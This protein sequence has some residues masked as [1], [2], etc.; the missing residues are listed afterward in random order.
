MTDQNKTREGLILE[1]Q[2]LQQKQ[3]LLES[4]YNKNITQ[5]KQEQAKLKKTE[6]RYAALLA[7]LNIGLVVHAPDTS[8]V[9]NNS[10]ASELLGISDDLLKGKKAIDPNW[11]FLDENAIPIPIEEYP[12]NKIARSKKIIK[13]FIVGVE[14]PAT[15]NIIWVS[16]NGFPVIDNK[17]EISEIAICFIDITQQKKSEQSLQASKDYLDKII[18]SVA[19][20]I[21][22]KDDTHRFCLVNDSLCA[23][24]NLKR[25]EL[26]GKKGYEHFPE[27][28]FE[29]FIAKVKEASNIGKE[30]IIEEL[31]K[32]GHGKTR[33]VVTNKTLYTDNEGNKFLIGV[34]NDVSELKQAE[35][36]LKDEKE[37]LSSILE[38]VENPIFLKDN[39][40]RITFA[41]RAF[42][43][44][45]GLDK[46]GVIGKTLAENLPKN[47]MEHFLKIDRSV[48][49]TG[50]PSQTE[51]EL[52]VG[53]KLH[54]IISSKTRLINKSG[55]KSIVGSLYDITERKQ[56]EEALRKSEEKLISFF[57][58]DISA[59]YLS[60]P[61]DK[62]IFCNK[63]FV[64]LFGFSSK[65][66]AMEYPVD[67]LYLNSST[68]EN[69]IAL[70]KK[71]RKVENFEC[72]FLTKD[73]R[74]INGLINSV[75]EFDQ[76]GKL[77]QI[78]GYI[79]DVTE[80]KIAEESLKKLSQAVEQSP[81]SIILTDTKGNIEYANPKTLE[82]T[83][84]E[85]EELIGKNPKIF[86]SGEK[87][88]SDYQELWKTILSGKEW[89]GEF[90]NVKK[91][92]KLFWELASISPILN[93]KGEITNYLAVKEDITEHKQILNELVVANTAL[94]FQNEE[95]EKRAAELIIANSELAFQNEEKEKRAAE[96][97]AAK[98]HAE[99]SDR[100]KSAFLANM[101]H[102]IRTPMNGI[103]GFAGLLK[104]PG[105]TGEKQQK[106]IKIIEKS[107][108]R[109][110]NI[111]N[112]IVDISKIESG[113]MKVY[114][115]ETNINEQIENINNFFKPE[116]EAKGIQLSVKKFLPEKE[117]ILK[118]DAEK[119][120]AILNN[121]VKNAIKFTNKGTIQLGV[122][123]ASSAT[124]KTE[125]EFFV[126]DTGIG[127]PK[128]R[129]KAVFERF[130]QADISDK[131]A[132]QGAGLG[133]S[134]AKAYAEM[135]GGKIWLES[136]VDIGSTFYFT[137]PCNREIEEKIT[138]QKDS[139]SNNIDNPIRNLKILIADDDESSEILL[140]LILEEFSSEI[141]IAKNGI[142]AVEICRNNPDLDL[143][144]MDIQMP[145]MSGYEATQQIR[146]FNKEVIIIAQT[147]YGFLSDREKT[148]KA[149]CNDYIA[150]P[151]KIDE[152][153]ALVQKYFN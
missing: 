151:I 66:E 55:E 109:M 2:K 84:Y 33:T 49:D 17:G 38:M 21:F 104:E 37:L 50:T 68:R 72:E 14:H 140:S 70:L 116:A 12:V 75:G 53:G 124:G 24:L 59:A 122:G 5:L 19:A 63:T 32:D 3:Y 90:H 119:I 113:L 95:K 144:L 20:P 141:L 100:L 86:S 134:I 125:L 23:F 89:R 27:A 85:L 57:E 123:F 149:G 6:E 67:K 127:I 76:A 64:K 111:I 13:D 145:E 41:N 87:P 31:I 78:K 52:T 136:E 88:K 10:K 61:N 45:F 146:Q 42:F 108:D 29:V 26:I 126:K 94:A 118:T 81:V 107:G 83:G 25:D 142:E 93:E 91:N 150:K 8:V 9:I 130:I 135:L 22:V 131:M 39:D 82:I 152:L 80:I 65:E 112:N 69:Y 28:Q 35:I 18:N 54:T 129:Q 128:D 138:I 71:N 132:M 34:L 120:N 30:N 96:L 148:L 77:I 115:K 60:T 62:I 79:I 99:E 46:N 133:L 114:L 137:I 147:A 121:L 97:I 98:E 117:A 101:S 105:L 51:E 74:I 4:L 58:D 73:N 36:M 7:Y 139:I 143:I 102:E 47:E 43:D 153:I 48:L 92:G 40:H 15:S 1:L 106:Y 44:L 56:A 11:H 16:V 103:L 110:L